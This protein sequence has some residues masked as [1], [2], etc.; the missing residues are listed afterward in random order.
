[1][2]LFLV[3]I[4]FYHYFPDYLILTYMM[5][6]F[7]LIV[8]NKFINT[9]LQIENK[10]LSTILFIF[11]FTITSF[12]LFDYETNPFQISQ[13]GHLYQYVSAITFFLFIIYFSFIAKIEE[14]KMKSFFKVFFYISLFSILIEVILVNVINLSPNL[15]PTHRD[16]IIYNTRFEIFSYLRPFG[17]TGSAPVNGVIMTMLMWI[18]YINYKSIKYIYFSIVPII[19]TASGTAY[20]CLLVSLVYYL[21]SVRQINKLNIL[22]SSSFVIIIFIY[23]YQAGF[24]KVN[25]DYVISFIDLLRIEENIFSLNFTHI[26]F[27]GLGNYP[28]IFS[29]DYIITEWYIIYSISRF[30]LIAVSILWLYL[31]I[32]IYFTKYRIIFIITFIG[33]LHVGTIL[34]MPTIL[35]LM[36]LIESLSKKNLSIKIK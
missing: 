33:S 7:L 9:E 22:L 32:N 14:D 25:P 26:L 4:I 29:N 31:F 11:L 13:G 28:E 36:V 23:L 3:P 35:I 15:I 16:S 8:L 12:T 5:S 17:L 20:I 10:V 2:I 18:N 24:Q 1:M 6:L 30:G 19:L 21:F 34:Y 27:G